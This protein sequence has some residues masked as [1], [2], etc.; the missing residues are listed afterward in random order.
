MA[1]DVH[2]NPQ[3]LLPAGTD[4]IWC[5]TTD[6]KRHGCAPPDP[7]AWTLR[8]AKRVAIKVADVTLLRTAA[9]TGPTRLFGWLT[10]WPTKRTV[11]VVKHLNRRANTTTDQR[12]VNEAAA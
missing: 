4:D 6:S 8:G 12:M 11:V 3:L 1:V 9:P 5:P 7:V 2:A 10:L